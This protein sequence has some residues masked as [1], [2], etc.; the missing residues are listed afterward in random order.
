MAASMRR[1]LVAIPALLVACVIALVLVIGWPDKKMISR[2]IG[3]ANVTLGRG[4][5]ICHAL[6]DSM[7]WTWL[8]HAIISPGWRVTWNALRR[9]Y[10][11]EKISA[12]DL[13]ALETMKTGSDWRLQDGADGLIRLVGSSGGPANESESSIFNPTNPDYIL[14]DGCVGDR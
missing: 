10:C 2:D 7:E 4:Q 13:T 3:C 8:G 1:P 5:E 12:A 9:V 11:R 6:S 14:K